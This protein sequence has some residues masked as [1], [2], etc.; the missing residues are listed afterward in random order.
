MNQIISLAAEK[1]SGW[2]F[3]VAGIIVIAVEYCIKPLFKST[4]EKTQSIVSKLSP[5]VLGALVYLVLAFI[6]KGTWYT[7]LAH[8]LLVGLTSMGSYD[9]ILKT[10][11]ESGLKSVT[12]TNEAVQKAIEG[13]K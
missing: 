1:L 9:V 11:K 13:D 3:I 5:I 2:D 10:M 7:S 12:D 6:Q 4:S 8:G